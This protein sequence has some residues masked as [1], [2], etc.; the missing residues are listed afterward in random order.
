MALSIQELLDDV[1]IAD[2]RG[3]LRGIVLEPHDSGYDEARRV[4][5]GMIDRRPRLIARCFEAG[6]VVEAVRFAAR[7]HLLVAVRGGGHHLAGKSVCDDGLMIDLSP[8][9]GIRVA[10]ELRVAEAQAGVLWGE[11]DAATQ[12]FGLAVTGGLISHTGVAGL[13][14]GG[15][16]GW[17]M[18]RYGLTVD[19]LLSVDIVTADG[20]LLSAS[21]EEHPDLF[22]AVRGGGGNFG[23]V[24][25]FRYRLH[26]VGPLVLAGMVLYPLT[27][28]GEVL[29]GF[30][31]A[32]AAAPD[33][34]GARV[35]FVTVPPAPFI[36]S[37]LQGT[38]ML[39][40]V[41]C[42]CGTLAQAA[43]ELAPFRAIG[44]PAIDAVQPMPYT[45]VQGMADASAPH[46]RQYYAKAHQ[47]DALSDGA[48]DVLVERAAISSSPH[49]T[50]ALVALGGAVGRVRPGSTAKGHR[51]AAFAL[52]MIS[53]WTDPGEAERHVRWTRDLWTALRPFAARGIYV[54]FLAEEDNAGVRDAYSPETWDRLVA[55]KNRYDPTNLFRLNQNIPPTGWAARTPA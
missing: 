13:T 51:D 50:V 10:P 11:L 55:L 34:V 28:A 18:R 20:R 3:R 2:L 7:H 38:R 5:N 54:N 33:G 37:Q 6:D 26:P 35:A 48:I 14:L 40:V 41:L 42:H 31:D 32:M 8:M 16:M 21:A 36:P 27:Q 49:S 29:R 44:M 45:A 39:A 46:G 23:I 52:E 25:R 22:W 9:K 53:S 1:A 19:N 43:R 15:G 30:R 17:L 4:W 47:F 12:A 24:T